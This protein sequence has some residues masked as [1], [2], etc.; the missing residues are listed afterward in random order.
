MDPEA[1]FFAFY[2]QPD[3]YQQYLAAQVSRSKGNK[4]GKN[5]CAVY[6]RPAVGLCD[7]VLGFEAGLSTQLGKDGHVDLFFGPFYR[8]S[9]MCMVAS[10]L[11]VYCGRLKFSVDKIK[12]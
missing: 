3:T 6:L 11:R 4:G 12:L 2:Y 9:G 10:Q 8:K 1:L 5:Q 7:G